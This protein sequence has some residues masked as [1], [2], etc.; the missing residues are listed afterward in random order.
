MKRWERG[1][2]HVTG[3][4]SELARRAFVP[5]DKVLLMIGFGFCVLSS[6]MAA[7]RYLCTVGGLQ[8]G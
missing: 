4:N 7:L 8:R 3:S 2:Q 1:G 5:K 6:E